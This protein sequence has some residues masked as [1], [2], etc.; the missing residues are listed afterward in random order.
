MGCGDDVLSLTNL[1]VDASRLK[2]L[3]FEG[4]YGELLELTGELLAP[5]DYDDC[6]DF[7]D[8]LFAE[9]ERM[10]DIRKNALVGEMGRLE[11]DGNYQEA[12]QFAQALIDVDTLS[13]DSHR[14]AMRLHFLA[15]DRAAALKAYERCE[16][17][18]EKE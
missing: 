1:E 13:E 12:I 14:H 4:G 5:H 7:A 3:S 11:K 18:L 16:A 17:I 6:P 15:G 8:W 9:R 10:A 2:V